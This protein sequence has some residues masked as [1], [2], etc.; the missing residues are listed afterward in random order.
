M[1]KHNTVTG[2]WIGM[3]TNTTDKKVYWLDSTEVDGGYTA[4]VYEDLG[5]ML[6]IVV[7]GYIYAG[8]RLKDSAGKWAFAYC[9]FDGTGLV[10]LCEK[11]I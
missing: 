5:D 2:A 3:K 1:K 9:K 10:I 11:S 8:E 6:E 7:C 4:W